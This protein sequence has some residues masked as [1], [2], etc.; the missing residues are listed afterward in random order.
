MSEP[1]VGVETARALFNVVYERWR[2]MPEASRPRLYLHGLSLGAYSSAAS[3]TLFDILEDPFD[4]ALWVG[5]PFAT[6]ACAP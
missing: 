5:P 2:D 4:G 6:A 3:S 1:D